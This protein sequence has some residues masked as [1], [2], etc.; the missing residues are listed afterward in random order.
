MLLYVCP[1]CHKKRVLRCF[2]VGN[3]QKRGIWLGTCLYCGFT[4]HMTKFKP[5]YGPG[6]FE[7]IK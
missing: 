3:G 6:T 7:E 1:R 5:V 2:Q 4:G